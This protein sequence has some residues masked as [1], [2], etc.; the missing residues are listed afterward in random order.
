MYVT[1]CPHT[2]HFN[3]IGHIPNSEV[4]CLPHHFLKIT[5]VLNQSLYLFSFILSQFSFPLRSQTSL[6]NHFILT[7]SQPEG[8]YASTALSIQP[9]SLQQLRARIVQFLSFTTKIIGCL[10]VR[11][12]CFFFF[13]G[14][15]FVL[16]QKQGTLSLLAQQDHRA[17]PPGVYAKSYREQIGYW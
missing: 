5:C 4:C 17:D 2:N 7:V 1:C 11:F 6:R 8:H 3:E 9:C 14:V 12:L 16:F 15:A 10:S 13:S